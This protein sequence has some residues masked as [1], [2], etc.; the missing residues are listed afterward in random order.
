MTLAIAH[1]EGDTAILDAVREIRAPFNPEA[2]VSEFATLLRSYRLA[3]VIGDKY[4]A[5]W[6]TSAFS[7]EGIH[8]KAA[9]Q[10]KSE[11]Y[12]GLL[13]GINAGA[14][15]LLDNDRLIRQFCQLERRTTRGEPLWRGRRRTI[16]TFASAPMAIGWRP[17][18]PSSRTSC[19][20]RPGG[21]RSWDGSARVS[22]TSP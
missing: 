15:S 1:Y 20:L 21:T 6:T 12:V 14:V 9:D 11:L 4:A 18:S 10:S 5:E 7:K 8:Y 17:S 13:P 16:T 2:A 19:A 22:R 3:R